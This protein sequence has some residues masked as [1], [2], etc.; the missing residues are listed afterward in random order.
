MAWPLWGGLISI[1][2]DSLTLVIAQSLKTTFYGD[3]QGKPVSVP[4]DPAARPSKQALQ[5]HFLE[6]GALMRDAFCRQKPTGHSRGLT[7]FKECSA[8]PIG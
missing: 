4:K 5:W 1:E 3:L 7:I 2:P 8:S 6:V